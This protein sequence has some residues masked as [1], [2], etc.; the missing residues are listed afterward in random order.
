MK[1]VVF[2]DDPTGS[3]TVFGCPLL[4]N[5]DRDILR[6]GFQNTSSLLFLLLNT[7][8]MHIQVARETVH[9]ACRNVRNIFKELNWIGQINKLASKIR[10]LDEDQ[11]KKLR[12][13]PS[14]MKNIISLE[15]AINRFVKDK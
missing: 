2:D 8:S 14:A 13:D 7:R 5:C 15:R 3:Q 4:L 12:S 6:K 9:T 10:A 1:I 11:S